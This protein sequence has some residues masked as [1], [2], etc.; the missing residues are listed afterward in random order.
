MLCI[1]SYISFIEKVIICA[2]I[3]VILTM[4]AINRSFSDYLRNLALK[5]ELSVLTGYGITLGNL[6]SIASLQF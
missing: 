6:L 3:E 5:L 1:A 2:I 4:C